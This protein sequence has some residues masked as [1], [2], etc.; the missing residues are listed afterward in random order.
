MA[1]TIDNSTII[2]ASSGAFAQRMFGYGDLGN[3]TVHGIVEA[4]GEL[5]FN[6]LTVVD[7]AQLCATAGH[8]LVVKCVS[9]C[10]IGEFAAIHAD[11]RGDR[12]G[13]GGIGGGGCSYLPGLAGGAPVSSEAGFA[14]GG[15]GG[16]KSRAGSNGGISSYLV[17]RRFGQGGTASNSGFAPPPLAENIRNSLS[18]TSIP[19]CLIA[20]AGGGG[21][22][23][24][25]AVGPFGRPG[26]GGEPCSQDYDGIGNGGNGY[27]GAID[28]GGGGGAGGAGGGSLSVVIG[29]SLV[30]AD[31]ARISANGG[32]GGNGG[33]SYSNSQLSGLCGG[34]G[35]GGGG[36]IVEVVL[37]RRQDHV[38]VDKDHITAIGGKGGDGN[39]LNSDWS[40]NGG[41]GEDG[42][43]G[44]YEV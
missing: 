1:R 34:G 31:T 18:V 27:D 32:N 24:G 10:C 38:N 9:N 6:K 12:G 4:G 25:D 39:T 19:S 8:K 28:A 30:I 43:V 40:N 14:G 35:G 22:T 21:G 36:G 11:G 29:G 3:V 33:K 42:F 20:S 17:G 2:T 37:P 23:G 44:I 15:G 5:S 13:E 16:G 41:D 26:K 7:G